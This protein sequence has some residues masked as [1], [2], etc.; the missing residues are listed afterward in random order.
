MD[1]KPVKNSSATLPA[2]PQSLD[3]TGKTS[4]T[5][6]A[7]ATTANENVDKAGS[8]RGINPNDFNLSLSTPSKE[9]AEAYKKALEIARKTPDVREDRV[10]EIK[11]KLANGTYN[12]DSG[13]I[14]DGMLREAIMEKLANTPE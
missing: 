14:A 9:R 6:R 11:K 4:G 12:V 2:G 13:A 3:Q 10:S 1:A 7:R 5:T 8:T